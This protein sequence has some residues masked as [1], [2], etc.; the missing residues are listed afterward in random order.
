M[1]ESVYACVYACIMCACMYI[2]RQM[3][4][5]GW[6]DVFVCVCMCVCSLVSR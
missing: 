3:N 5:H 4:K 2:G 6:L 1:Y